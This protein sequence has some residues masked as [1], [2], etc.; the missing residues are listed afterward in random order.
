MRAS[1]LYFQRTLSLFTSFSLLGEVG[2]GGVE[3]MALG[4]KLK[5]GRP[6]EGVLGVVL[7]GP[8]RGGG[9]RW[10]LL[11]LLRIRR[12]HLLDFVRINE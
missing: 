6:E 4:D 3:G 1:A 9:S 10:R 12:H 7:R 8:R 2:G 11:V 5:G